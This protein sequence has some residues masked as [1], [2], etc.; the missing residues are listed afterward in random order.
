MRVE[1]ALVAAEAGADFVG[2]VFAES[3]RRLSTEEALEIVRALGTPLAALEQTEPPP[4]YD[5]DQR[6]V[7]AWF[8]HGARALERLL[9]R[10]RPLTVGV[11]QG[12]PLEQVNSLADEAGV[13]LI[14]L[15]GGESWR[16][17]LLANRQV[18]KAVDTRP[19]A[20][21]EALLA[22]LESGTAIACLLDASRGRGRRGDWPLAAG[23]AG[24]LPLILAGGLTPQNVAEA[25][26]QVHPWGVDVSSGVETSGAKD[27]AKVRAFIAA[28]RGGPSP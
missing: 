26:R 22:S 27:P 9:L 12:Q 1:D 21:V 11:F 10:K 25:V 18:I 4:H 2:L 20:S 16:D 17:C 3:P 6:D 24:R 5:G 8:H 7:A 15:S 23:L 14:Q 19:F 28:A 13:D